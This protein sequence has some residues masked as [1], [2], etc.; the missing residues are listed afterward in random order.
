VSWRGTW[1]RN[2]L[3][4]HAGGSARLSMEASARASFA[5]SGTGVRWIGYGDEWSGIAEVWLDGRL[6]ASVD[7]HASPARPQVELYVVEGLAAGPH[8]LTIQPTGRHGPDSGG[9]WI[10]IDAFKVLR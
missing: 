7:T 2:S 8:T 9:S 3:A 10:W 4:V 5:F 1:S 6:R